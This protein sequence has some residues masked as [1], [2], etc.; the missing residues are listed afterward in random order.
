MYLTN[1]DTVTDHPLVTSIL[2]QR[3]CYRCEDYF[4][5]GNLQQDWDVRA[6]PLPSSTACGA[7]Q[8]FFMAE[9]SNCPSLWKCTFRQNSS[10]QV[11]GGSSVEGGKL[12]SAQFYTDLEGT[13]LF[14]RGNC[15]WNCL[16]R[17]NPG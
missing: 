16:S 1:R 7:S 9:R 2:V 10:V 13:N 5:D 14:L 3:S 17:R 11:F 15:C 8:T 6:V 4:C 12:R